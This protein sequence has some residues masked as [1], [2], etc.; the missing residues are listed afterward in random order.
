M[1]SVEEETSR[2]FRIRR[3]LMQMLRDRG[4]PATDMNLTKPQFIERFGNPTRRDDLMA[5][6]AKEKEPFDPVRPL[7]RSVPRSSSAA[8]AL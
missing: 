3:T 6:R 5:Y 2:L 7:S 4:Y 1:A 8:A